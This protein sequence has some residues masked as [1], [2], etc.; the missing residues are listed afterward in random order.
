MALL[1]VDAIHTYY[2]SIEALRG[3]SLEV[4]AGEVV[5]MIGS[6]GAGKS[7]TLRS[8]SGLSPARRGTI[9]F[10]GREITT[11]PPS[12]IVG[13]GISQV[14][15]GRRCFPRMSV[16]ENLELGA[17]LRPGAD[18]TEDL[19][20]VFELFPVL[21]GAPRRRRRGRCRAASSRCWRSAGR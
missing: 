19:D 3:V 15:E 9:R 2:G 12:R 20:R 4:G 11:M 18:L 17:Y 8:I 10:D 21:A 7:T 1:E 14:P 13:L 6:N 16:R 5:T